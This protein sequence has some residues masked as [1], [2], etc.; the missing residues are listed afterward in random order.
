[1]QALRPGIENDAALGR[2]ALAPDDRGRGRGEVAA[3]V[4]PGIGK[5]GGPGT[6]VFDLPAV[7]Y[8]GTGRQGIGSPD[9]LDFIECTRRN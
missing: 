2:R 8:S 3:Y 6:P 9:M 1:M 5:M 4:E 7:R